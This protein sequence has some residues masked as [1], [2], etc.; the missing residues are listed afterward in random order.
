MLGIS[1]VVLETNYGGQIPYDRVINSIRL[2]T[3]RVVPK[4]Q[5]GNGCVGK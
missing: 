5:V 2:L 4:F 1:S 3:E